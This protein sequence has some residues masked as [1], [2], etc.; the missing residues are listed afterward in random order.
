MGTSLPDFGQYSTENAGQW[1]L[2]LSYEQAQYLTGR[3][4]GGTPTLAGAAPVRGRRRDQGA[5]RSGVAAG[6]FPCI[7]LFGRAGR[8]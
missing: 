6:D 8:G 3:E 4:I 1:T 5:E 7:E 2:L